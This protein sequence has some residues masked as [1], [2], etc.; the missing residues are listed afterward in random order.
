M[1]SSPRMQNTGGENGRGFPLS[2][3]RAASR[4]PRR[5]RLLVSSYPRETLGP[6]AIA[7]AS[8]LIRRHKR[9][10]SFLGP[11]T[12]RGPRRADG[13]AT[14]I[15]DEEITSTKPRRLTKGTKCQN[16][17]PA[18]M[19]LTSLRSSRG[20]ASCGREWKSDWARWPA[21]SRT[22]A[23]PSVDPRVAR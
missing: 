15:H 2:V 13:R 7:V 17:R 4:G 18:G 19:K 22:R 8:S 23:G 20:D 3:G 21:R 12:W 14:T 16:Q 5:P 10:P 9:V 1:R 6:P 11:L